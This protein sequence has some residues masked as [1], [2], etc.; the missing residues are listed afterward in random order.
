MNFVVFESLTGK[1]IQSGYCEDHQ[2]DIQ[3]VPD[4]CRILPIE[5]NPLT[6][7]IQ[8]DV[9]VEMPPCPGSDYVFDYSLKKWIDAFSPEEKNKIESEKV[10]NKRNF[11]L[12]KS[13]WTQIP[14]NPLTIEK[15]EEWAVYRQQLRDIT[16]QPGYPF[17]V[18]WPI[19]PE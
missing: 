2:F 8:N 15:Q 18:D 10:I 12:E 17:N 4:G 3:H 5:A 11:L 1:I 13:D 9:A 7:Y 16:N 6:D 19:K 14:N